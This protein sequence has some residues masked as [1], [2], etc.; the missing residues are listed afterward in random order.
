MRRVTGIGGVFFKAQDPQALGRWYQ[1]HLGIDIQDWGGAAF[2]W[3]TPEHPEPHGCTVWSP[4]PADTEYFQPP[5]PA[6]AAVGVASLPRGAQ[7][8]MDA[9]LELDG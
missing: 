7:V 8:E 4:F 5:Y 9:V 6:R 3:Q 1:E 2:S